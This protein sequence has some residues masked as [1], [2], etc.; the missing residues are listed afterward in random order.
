VTNAARDEA[1]H[2]GFDPELRID[3]IEADQLGDD[4]PGR[5]GLT[6]L[7][8]KHGKSSRYPGRTYQRDADAD[9]A[10]LATAGARVLI[11]LVEDHELQQWSTPQLVQRGAALGVTVIRFPIADGHPPVDLAAMGAILDAVRRGRETGDVAVACMGGVGR[12]GTVA[13]CALVQAGLDADAAIAEVR[14]VRHPQAVE[15]RAQD[16]FV[17]EFEASA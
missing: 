10:A 7:P 5:L 3:W 8:G 13:A 9:L 2:A 15:T 12:T 11:L 6:I 4:R 1:A 14:R 16:A 17:R